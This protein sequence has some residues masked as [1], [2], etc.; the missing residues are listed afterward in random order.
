MLF[1][2]VICPNIVASSKI[3]VY[4]VSESSGL[5]VAEP[6]YSLPTDFASVCSLAVEVEDGALDGEDG[7]EDGAMFCTRQ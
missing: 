7:V 5:S 6:K 2:G 3:A 1:P 4:A